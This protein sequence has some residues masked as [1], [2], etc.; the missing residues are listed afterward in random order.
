VAVGQIFNDRYRLDS[1]LGQGGTGA[2]WLG[3]DTLLNRPV[4]VKILR[5][6]TPR[7]ADRFLREARILA[8]LRSPGVVRILDFGTAP[9]GSVFMVMEY[10]AGLTLAGRLLDGPLSESETLAL[11]ASVAR[12]LSTVHAA[13]IVHLDVKPTNIMFA[14]DGTVVLVD[15]GGAAAQDDLRATRSA[16]FTGT[17]FYLAPE[18][19]NGGPATP[20]TDLY[21]LGVVAYECLTGRHPFDGPTPM[22]VASKHL[23]ETPP[24]LPAGVSPTAASLVMRALAKNPADRWPTAASMAQAAD[25]PPVIPPPSRLKLPGLDRI[26]RPKLV[27]GITALV[28]AAA[29]ALWAIPGSS[30]TPKRP[31]T[32]TLSTAT[33]AAAP[34]PTAAPP[35]VPD[36]AAWW[37]FNKPDALEL[38]GKA[39]LEPDAERDGVLTMDGLSGYATAEVSG[40]DPA[41][42]FT[43]AVWARLSGGESGPS[44]VTVA[45]VP[46]ENSSVFF[47][48]YKSTWGERGWHFIMSH[49]DTAEPAV[50]AAASTIEPEPGRWYFVAGVH[51]PEARR[52]S[53][54]VDGEL[55]GSAEHT[56]IWTSAKPLHL[57]IH[58]WANSQGGHWPGSLDKAAVYQR[59]LSAEEIKALGSW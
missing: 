14:P 21:A 17:P 35:P 30:D 59:A 23:T 28:T 54:Y 44:D 26:K 43:I 5:V 38:E 49:A 13:G 55:Q 20:V 33:P 3:L 58:L 46:G 15:F 56:N 25:R 22:A 2:V 11:I 42:A 8:A 50:D 47:L 45:S 37:Q 41:K 9:D 32:R 16:T 53:L 31:P 39:T 6:G 48:Q 34:T 12:S 27:A 36:T 10:V 57:G 1:L 52:I 29:V 51:D 40:F 24:P 4:A 7:A 18:Q 19:V